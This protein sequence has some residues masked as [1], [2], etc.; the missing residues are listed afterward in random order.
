MKNPDSSTLNEIHPDASEHA[1]YT[2]RSFLSLLLPAPAL[3]RVAF[4]QQPGTPRRPEEMA[5]LYRRMSEDA[6]RKGLAEAFKGITTNGEVVPGL[7]PIH[8][9]GVSTEPIRNAAERFLSSL[10]AAQRAKTMFAV[11][12]PEWRKWMNQHFYVRQGVSFKEMTEAQRSAAFGL[13]Q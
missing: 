10:N 6:E 7:F 4:A 12:D 3:A 11:D 13:L 8:S 2:R 1:D 5:E 9:T